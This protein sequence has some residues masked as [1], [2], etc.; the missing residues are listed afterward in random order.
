MADVELSIR[1]GDG[2]DRCIVAEM[3]W[4]A[5]HPLARVGESID[6]DVGNGSVRVKV[7]DVIHI[8]LDTASVSISGSIAWFT[9]PESIVKGLRKN[10]FVIRSFIEGQGV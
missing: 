9:D 1:I 4:P 6:L 7:E 8:L 10:K 5:N 2:D 3:I